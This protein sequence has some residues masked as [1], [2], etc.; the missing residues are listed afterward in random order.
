MILTYSLKK[1]KI[2]IKEKNIS[3][4]IEIKSKEHYNNYCILKNLNEKKH[5]IYKEKCN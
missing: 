2:E 3:Y 4:K 1:K 5:K